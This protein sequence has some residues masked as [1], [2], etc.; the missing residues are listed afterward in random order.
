MGR[1][2]LPQ[3]SEGIEAPDPYTV[4]TSSFLEHD[5]DEYRGSRSRSRQAGARGES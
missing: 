1:E 5:R 4:T 3:E 2:D